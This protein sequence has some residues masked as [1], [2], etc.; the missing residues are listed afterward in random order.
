VNYPIDSG[1]LS[2]VYTPDAAILT[3]T[4]SSVSSKLAY[5][6]ASYTVSITP[7]K[8]LPSGSIIIVEFPSEISL[9]GS[10]V[11]TCKVSKAG[12]LATSYTDCSLDFT[13]P[14]T[15]RIPS[16]F[17]SAFTGDGSTTIEI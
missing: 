9:S 2:N 14:V 4:I 5:D 1:T 6:T 17:V 3:A 12:A 8:T 7:E 16:V 10:S 11:T 15:F 13:S